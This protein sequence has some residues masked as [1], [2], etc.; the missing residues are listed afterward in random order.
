MKK[1]HPLA[2]NI[3]KIRS[4]SAKNFENDI[5]NQ[6][7]KLNMNLFVNLKLKLILIVILFQQ[8]AMIM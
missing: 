4:I 5:V 8:M 6:L 3:S 7:S 2:K 1:Y